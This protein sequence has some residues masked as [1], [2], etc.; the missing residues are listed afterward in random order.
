[1][2][3]LHRLGH[4]LPYTE[5]KFIED[6]WVELSKKQPKLVP[7]NFRE[8]AHITHVIDNI[9]WKNQTFKGRE[10]HN[11]NSI[12]IQ[13]EYVTEHTNQRN[14]ALKPDIVSIENF[15]DPLKV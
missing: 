5:T 1:M 10:T 8:G 4:E 2:T 7:N 12:I 11:A 9:D 14:V 15:I 13:Q 6:K 3:D